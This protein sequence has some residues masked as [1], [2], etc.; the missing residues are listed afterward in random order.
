[1]TLERSAKVISV[2]PVGELSLQGQP[3]PGF[4]T[5]QRQLS[6]AYVNIPRLNRAGDEIGAFQARELLRRTL[7]GKQITFTIAYTIPQSQRQYG[8]VKVAGQDI[9]STL[10]QEGWAKVRDEAGKKDDSDQSLLELYRSQE[11][12]ARSE[13]KGLWATDS[14]LIEANYDNPAD[15]RAFLA[16]YQGKALDAVIEQVRA[17]DS[18]RARIILSPRK[19]QYLTI[20]IAGIKAPSSG[21]TNADGSTEPAEEHG[22]TAKSFVDARLLQRSVQ[23]TLLGTNQSASAYIGNILH[24]AGNIAEAL[25]SD[26]LARV[27]DHQSAMLGAEAIGKLRAAETGAKQRKLNLWKA[28]VVKANATGSIDGTV[29]RVQSADTIFVRLKDGQEKR[30]QL[31]S[32]R[33]PKANDAKQAPFAA[34]AKEFLRKKAIGKHVVISHLFKKPASEGYDEREVATITLGKDNLAKLLTERGYVLVIRH[35]RDDEDRSPIWDELIAAEETSIAEAKGMHTTKAPAPAGRIVEASENATRAK[36]YLST[37]QR[38]KRVNAV[39]E[40]VASGGRFKL[41]VPRENAKLTFVLSGI[42]VPRTARNASESS[43]PF[44]QEAAEYASRK[45]M[46]RDVEVE[47][48]TTDKVGGFIGSL[49]INRENF[50][51]GLLEEGFASMHEYSAEQSGNATLYREAENRAREA[52]KGTWKDYVPD[53]VAQPTADA[54]PAKKEYIDV[55]IC[56]ANTTTGTFSVQTVGDNVKQLEKLMQ[57][58]QT[59][60]STSISQ[61]PRAGELVAAKF[62]EDN[63]WYRGKV[64][65]V[66]RTTNKAE[67]LYY[68]FGNTE[69]IP[70]KQLASLPSKFTTLPPQAKEARLSYLALPEVP[71]YLEDAINYLQTICQMQLVGCVDKKDSVLSLTLYDPANTDPTDSIN[72][73]MVEEGWATVIPAEK[74]TWE[75]GSMSMVK[76]LQSKQAE[77]LKHRRGMFEFGDI[78]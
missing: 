51:V 43:E 33:A 29:S 36:Q 68:D 49:Y 41:Y 78:A 37:L 38:H 74:M 34:E 69:T 40:Y 16:E 61:A 65:R 64:K 60:C 57:E 52:R 66:D 35:R 44:G 30:L 11:A 55:V 21:R 19:H 54:A 59:S 56:D 17:G 42:K 28:H 18:V 24:P 75:K 5:P 15:V 39:V 73:K 76:S 14:P 10:L 25:L 58:L 47:V 71:E 70:I 12:L 23:I 3:R 50:A 45:C 63:T 46:Q 48:E 20:L 31:S 27:A 4:P 26:G 67:I 13:A 7:V 8:A 53:A 2:S 77:A 6:L 62:S 9:S 72:A 22:E 1:M 32:V